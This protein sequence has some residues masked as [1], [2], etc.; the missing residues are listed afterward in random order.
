LEVTLTGT[1]LSDDR[2][3]LDGHFAPPP[4][5]VCVAVVAV[6]DR[7]VAL[8]KRSKSGTWPGQWCLPGGRVEQGETLMQCCR[9]ELAQETGLSVLRFCFQCVTECLGPPHLVGLVYRART[10]SGELTNREPDRHDEVGWFRWDDLPAPL[11]PGVAQYLEW[12]E[13]T[14]ARS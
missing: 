6:R 2:A 3:V 11:M 1:R 12:R 7:R 13:K 14:H 4:P 8:L 5:A 9:R 10:V